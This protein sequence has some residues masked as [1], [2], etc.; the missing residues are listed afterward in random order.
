MKHLI[1]LGDG[2]ADYPIDVLGGKTVLE[3]ARTP[4][5]DRMAAEGTLGLI[6]TI[7]QGLPPGS[8]VANLSVLGYDP[9]ECYTG[10]GPL[11]AANMGIALSPEDVAFRCNL[12]TLGDGVDPVMEDFTA[13]HISSMEAKR[14]IADLEIAIGSETFCFHPG[15]GYRH[16][17]VWKGGES[18]LVATPPHDI[19]DKAIDPYLPQ[20]QGAEQINRLMRLSREFLADHPVNRERRERGLKPATSIWLWGQGRAPRIRK[21][22]ERFQIRGG[23]ISAVDL[24]NGIGVYAGLEVIPVEGATGYTDTNYRGKAEKALSVLK[25]LDLIFI[26]VEAPDEM[27]HEG[28]VEG[29]VKAIED[30]DAQVVGTVLQGIG[31]LGP[32]RIAVLSDHPT[33]LSLKT[34][35]DDPSPFAV[36]SSLAGENQGRGMSF[37]EGAAARAGNLISPGYLFMETFIGNWRNFIGKDTR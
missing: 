27:G 24:L 20:G 35:V 34:H 37:G 1:L 4:H 17:L 3:Y 6:D 19:T 23:V 7:P 12:V 9:R 14:I 5:M 25:E 26:H 16:L 18:E 30:F 28:N 10:R 33:P 21:M 8:D 31:N 22:M 13:G 29:K 15:V 36:L 32:F 11:E 2:M